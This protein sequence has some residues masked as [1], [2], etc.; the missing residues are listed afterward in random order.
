[1]LNNGK[2]YELLV[3]EVYEILNSIDGLEDV[4][5]QHD[6][7]LQGNAR[8]HQI[9]VYWEFIKAGIP[10]RVV[11]ECKDYKSPVKAEKIE[12][13]QA[14]LM[15]LN[16]PIGIY[17]SKHGYQEG[18]VKVAK[19]YGIQLMVIH[20][21]EDEDWEGFI[22]TVHI[23]LV[24]QLIENV[25]VR[26]DVDGDWAKANGIT[27][28]HLEGYMDSEVF[29]VEHMEDG[30]EKRQSLRCIAERFPRDKEGK[31]FK[32]QIEYGNET[33]LECDDFKYQIKGVF[34][35]YDI[36]HYHDSITI[37]AGQMIKAFIKNV[38]DDEV[39]VMDI[40][41]NVRLQGKAET[42]E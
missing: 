31:G 8:K 22:K 6:I 26:V 9:D 36:H 15:D 4:K 21:P 30:T 2:E 1:M 34:F 29:V 28:V 41:G 40:R 33:C 3:K 12:A 10:F 13:F 35:M 37:D 38:I 16:N 32:K 18:A 14:T 39:K 7:R 23:K 17:V 5:I 25:R 27:E 11:V 24:L 20:G 19:H 42:I